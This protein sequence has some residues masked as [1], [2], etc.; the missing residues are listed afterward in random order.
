VEGETEELAKKKVLLVAMSSF[1][2]LYTASFI[3]PRQP[4]PRSSIS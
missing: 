2:S 4:V 1:A 3:V